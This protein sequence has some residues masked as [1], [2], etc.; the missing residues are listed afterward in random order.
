M[1]RHQIA[2]DEK[3]YPY[4]LHWR[5]CRELIKLASLIVEDAKKTRNK[6]EHKKMHTDYD[7]PFLITHDGEI[8]RKDTT[9]ILT[10]IYSRS[11]FSRIRLY[12]APGV[13]DW[14]TYFDKTMA[15]AVQYIYWSTMIREK[16][17]MQRYMM[18]HIHWATHRRLYEWIWPIIWIRWNFLLSHKDR[19]LNEAILCIENVMDKVTLHLNGERKRYLC[20]SA[21][22]AADLTFASHAS[23]ILWPNKSE[24]Y[25]DKM[26]IHV[27]YLEDISDMRLINVVQHWKKTPA[28][29]LAIRLYRSERGMSIGKRPPRY[30]QEHNPWWA[31][32]KSMIYL[33]W[34]VIIVMT[35]ILSVIPILLLRLAVI[36]SKKSLVLNAIIF[37]SLLMMTIMFMR[38]IY[39]K[40]YDLCI[41]YMQ[42]YRGHIFAK[43]I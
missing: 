40:H 7:F 5:K 6:Q 34:V 42:M 27:P 14:E 8:L 24:D 37:G 19:L 2:Y 3:E 25:M 43:H 28:A 21:F 32:H 13:L 38:Y 41:N 23:L 20:G 30:D 22:S 18:R 31:L 33:P 17:C 9:Q 26:K 29:Q 11:L 12:R 36:D 1:D 39:R 16:G 10:Y 15:P 35:V 4:G